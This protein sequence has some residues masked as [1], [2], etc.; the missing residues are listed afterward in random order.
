MQDKEP[1]LEGS[2]LLI[3]VLVGGLQGRPPQRSGRSLQ[4]LRGGGVV[5]PVPVPVPGVVPLPGGVAGG[6][7]VPSGLV[8]VPGATDGVAGV[9]ASGVVVPLVPEV[10]LPPVPGVVAGAVLGVAAGA[11]VVDS[12]CL[13]QPPS[14]AHTMAVPRTSLLVLGSGAVMIVPFSLESCRG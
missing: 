3:P 9:V 6:V 14:S 5:V 2:L 13:L 4:L 7:V 11:V 12:L 8:T 10:P 1:S